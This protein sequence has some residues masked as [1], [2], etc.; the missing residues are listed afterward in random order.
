MET[1]SRKS[2]ADRGDGSRSDGERKIR[3]VHGDLT[4]GAMKQLDE[5]VDKF[6]QEESRIEI[7]V[8]GS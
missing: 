1:Q 8:I 7:E 5:R 3:R 6:W 4:P 2:F